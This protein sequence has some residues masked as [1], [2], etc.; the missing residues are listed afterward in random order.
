MKHP[1]PYTL[2]P[3]SL[4][5]FPSTITAN[6]RAL[7]I[8]T[9]CLPC[10]NGAHAAGSVAVQGPKWNG[11]GI[12]AVQAAIADEATRR[13]RARSEAGGT[14]VTLSSGFGNFWILL[15]FFRQQSLRF[16][17]STLVPPSSLLCDF[18]LISITSQRA[19]RPTTPSLS[20]AVI[21]LDVLRPSHGQ[22][23]GKLQHKSNTRRVI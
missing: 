16:L 10:P 6:S 20:Y 8:V 21:I 15:K 22:R 1:T 4:Q 12:G 9:L 11:H 18:I 7:N 2:A 3:N 23:S 19:M 5:L 14:F 13:R 17:A